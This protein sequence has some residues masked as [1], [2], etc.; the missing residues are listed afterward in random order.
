MSTMIPLALIAAL[1]AAPA[2]ALH[3][4]DDPP[5]RPRAGAEKAPAAAPAA[6]GN[7]MTAP[8]EHHFSF[9][10]DTYETERIKTLQVWSQ[11]KQADLKFRPEKRARTPLEQMIHQCASE[12]TWMKNM[13]QIDSGLPTFP[14]V[15]NKLELMKHYA[16]ASGKRLEILRSKPAPWWEEKT[17]FFDVQRS[18]AW[19][20]LRRLTHS[21]HHRAQLTVYLRLLGRPLY[22]VYGPTADTGGLY[23]NKA[24]TIYRYDTLEDLMSA[25]A[26]GREGR[27]LPG[28]GEKPPTER[29]DK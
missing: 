17:A 15:E 2:L 8:P 13:L 26:E 5:D 19:I 18:R 4:E 9:M 25:E 3:D 23:S 10:A 20:F 7:A 12:D 27:P 11:F 14:K 21:A 16:A 28:P 29:P 22:S 1:A 24:K 6:K